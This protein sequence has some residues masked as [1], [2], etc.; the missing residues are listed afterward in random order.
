[1]AIAFAARNGP[2]LRREIDLSYW[3][4]DLPLCDGKCDCHIVNMA[5]TF[6]A[7]ISAKCCVLGAGWSV[8]EYG[9]SALARIAQTERY[10]ALS[11][12]SSGR[13]G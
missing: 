7:E 4:Y 8:Q 2:H 3:Q 6:A 5:I 1:M 12:E 13:N 9:A 11:T 10:P